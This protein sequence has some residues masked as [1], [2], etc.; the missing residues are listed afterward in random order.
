MTNV[1][2]AI[3]GLVSVIFAAYI[4]TIIPIISCLNTLLIDRVSPLNL[5]NIVY[6][7][8]AK[9]VQRNSRSFL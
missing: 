7:E 4:T 6:K 5:K 1:V 9:N 2:L 3:F 8:S